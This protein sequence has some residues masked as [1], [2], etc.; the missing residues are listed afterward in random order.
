MTEQFRQW[1]EQGVDLA[2]LGNFEE[3]IAYF[4]KALKIEPDAPEAWYEQGV[5]LASLRKV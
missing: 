4:D 5:V 3:A 1:F 2:K